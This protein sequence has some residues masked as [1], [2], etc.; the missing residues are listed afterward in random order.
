VPFSKHTRPLILYILLGIVSDIQ[1]S[2][3]LSPA[4]FVKAVRAVIDFVFLSQLP[5]QTS[6]SLRALKQ[7]LQLFHDNKS[8]FIDLGIRENFNIPKLHSCRHYIPSIKLF[9]STDNYNTQHT[10][11]EGRTPTNDGLVRTPGEDSSP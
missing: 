4:R 3:G 11:Y 5:A 10:E 1:L 6:D 9:G 8:I 7:A 2:Q